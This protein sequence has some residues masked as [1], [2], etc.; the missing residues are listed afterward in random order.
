MAAVRLG[1]IRRVAST[2]VHALEM[3]TAVL[4]DRLVMDLR[5]TRGLSYS[6]GAR[7]RVDGDRAVFSARLNPPTA[8]L[9]EGEAALATALRDFDAATITQDELDRV[10][11]ARQGRLMMRRLDSISR[12][13]YLAMA[14]LD[15]DVSSYLQAITAYDTVTLDDL[16]RVSAFFS[17][18]PL[19]TVVVD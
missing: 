17:E 8:R 18:L 16:R 6:V 11:G 2:D 10:R 5:E 13:Y 19:V 9:A 3:L 15:G 1:A 4:S 12:A 7:M 14:E